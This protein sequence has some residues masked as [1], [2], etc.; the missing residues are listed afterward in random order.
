MHTHRSFARFRAHR[1]AASA[2]EFAL[3]AP[4]FLAL[5]FGIIV[6]GCVLGIH[7]GV[8]QLAAEAARAAVAGL[9]DRECDE[10]ARSYVAKNV[11]AYPF[12]D[13]SKLTVSTAT[14]AG[15]ASGFSVS[16]SYDLSS[17]FVFG[18]ARLVPT[19]ATTVLRS[20]VVQRGGF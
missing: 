13:P 17:S 20:A 2:V 6:F 11:G 18:L 8:Q 19:P 15:P 1:G 12:L 9:S 14:T 10:I 4:C 16:L 5:V 7:H 3:I